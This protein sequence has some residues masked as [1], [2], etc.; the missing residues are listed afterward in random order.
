M[1]QIMANKNPMGQ[2]KR[3]KPGKSGLTKPDGAKMR[4]LER[5]RKALELRKAGATFKSIADQLG[6]AS[7]DGAYKAVKALLE[8]T[9]S[10]PTKELRTVQY[11]RLNHM[12]LVL[13]PRVQDGDT[14]AINSALRIMDKIDML[15]GTEE[16]SKSESTVHHAGSIVIDGE[17]NDYIDALRKARDKGRG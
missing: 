9:L 10:E 1:V 15:Y 11:E 7:P 16:P 6:Y 4:A 12:I 8:K 17:K 5:Q 13:W 2:K 3:K 14:A